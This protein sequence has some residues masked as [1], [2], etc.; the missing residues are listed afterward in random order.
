M[1]G[2][3]KVSKLRELRF[4]LEENV[5]KLLVI[6]FLSLAA[7]SLAA[8]TRGIGYEATANVTSVQILYEGHPC[9]GYLV[10]GNLTCSFN[11]ILYPITHVFG[12]ETNSMF[13]GKS[14]PYDSKGTSVTNTVEISAAFQEF[15]KNVPYY[16]AVSL[17][18]TFGLIKPV[19]RFKTALSRART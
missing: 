12:Y 15:F 2:S 1:S 18:A 17:V 14:E 13:T 4:W 10:T 6:G 7:L 16:L 11:P 19:E 8:L 9:L 5:K 3:T